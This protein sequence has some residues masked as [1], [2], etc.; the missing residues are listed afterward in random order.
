MSK[1]DV[2][3]E[4]ASLEAGASDSVLL[5][6]M[7]AVGM[8]VVALLSDGLAANGW[9]CECAP[10][11]SIFRQHLVGYQYYLFKALRGCAKILI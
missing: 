1:G 4:A 2:E 5:G 8:L 7:G 9:I 3:I 6:R 10:F 11:R